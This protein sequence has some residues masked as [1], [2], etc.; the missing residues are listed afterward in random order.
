M[1]LPNFPDSPVIGQEITVGAATYQCVA[2]TPKPQ[3]RLANQADK[4]LRPDLA[5]VNSNV[6]IAGVQAAVLARQ[7]VNLRQFGAK[8]DGTDETIPVLNWLTY[9][10]NNPNKVG[11]A[12]GGVFNV[13]VIALNVPNGLNIIGSATF[14]AIGASRL[15]MIQLV[16]ATGN[17]S[18]DGLTIDG[19]DIVARPFEIQNIGNATAGNVYIGPRCRFIN[20]KNVAPR[21]DNA[22]GC[23]VV[24]NFD[25]V[26]FEGEVDGVD[27]NL[28]SGA[29]SVGA[30]FDWSGTSVIKRVVITSKARIKNVKTSNIVTADADGVQRMGPTNQHLQFTVQEGAYFENCK[31]RAI[32]SQVKGNSINGPVILRNAYD[33]VVEID[34]QHAG[35]YVKG[36]R[37]FHDG[38]RVE[39][40][41]GSTTRDHSTSQT[42]IA[43]NILTILNPPAVNT[44]YM[45][46]Y[47]GVD[48]TDSITQRGVLC[49]GNKVY[50]GAV[51]HFVTVYAANTVNTNRAVIRDN[52]ADV[53]SNAF[54]E[55]RPVF[56]NPAQ[57]TVVFENNGCQSNCVGA[58]V[59]PGGQLRVASDRCNSKISALPVHPEIISGG[60]LTLYAGNFIPVTTEGAAGYDD[61]DTITGGNYANGELVLFKMA[62]SGQRPTFKNGTGNIFLAGSDFE[63]NSLRDSLL[64]SYNADANEWHE[65][66]RLNNG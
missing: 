21:E 63:L 43:D 5:D 65:V 51:K 58:L 3:W 13:G 31:G 28:T 36:A 2:L 41:V 54:I 30:W 37:V 34:I 42:T 46:F 33:G 60:V 29:V 8:G 4:G 62:S 64:L 38:C 16:G 25:N 40:V 61:I 50:G 24:G 55:L 48:T 49:Y 12:E 7:F 18:I 23:R 9:L 45:C 1:A 57:L 27:N 53:V 17:I 47:W 59:A 32:K 14:K 44:D 15:Y 52:W 26:V 10:A 35:G 11:I 39:T 6:Q 56:N 20:A 19:S 66:S 22:G